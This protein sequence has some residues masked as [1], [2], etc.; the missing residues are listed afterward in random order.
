MS[1]IFYFPFLE[2]FRLR[3]KGCFMCV[4]NGGCKNYGQVTGS[5]IL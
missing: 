5:E 2:A 3:P 1:V 4:P